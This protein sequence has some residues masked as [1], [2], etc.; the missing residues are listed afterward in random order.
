M[1]SGAH[2]LTRTSLRALSI[3][4]VMFLLQGATCLAQ[5]FDC[6]KATTEIEKTICRNPSLAS[7]DAAMGEVYQALLASLAAGEKGAFKDAQRLWI[8][9]RNRECV[10]SGAASQ[11]NCLKKLIDQRHDELQ[12]QLR[13]KLGLSQM[14]YDWVTSYSSLQDVRAAASDVKDRFGDCHNMPPTLNPKFVSLAPNQYQ[15]LFA[16]AT[17]QCDAVLRVY[18]GCAGKQSCGELL[19]L[20]DPAN[21]QARALGKLEQE[22]RTGNSSGIFVPVAFAKNGRNIILKAW[23]GS[24]G[25]GGGLVNYGYE[26]MPRDGGTSQ[27]SELAP[28]GA[29]FYSDFG[30]AVYTKDSSKLPAF[31]QPGP[32]SNNGL[33][34]AKDLATLKERPVLEEPDTT[35]EILRADERNHT[36]TIRATQHVFSASCP[37]NQ[38]D[39]LLCSKKTAR[40]RQIPLP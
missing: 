13:K 8:E 31:T 40:E 6:A 15:S 24:P 37:R 5:S 20:E 10:G 29:V 39:S 3:F 25:A 34:V 2:L 32:P 22:S 33:L 36:L 9:K 11:Q 28:N 21:K 30:M 35:F 27:R 16:I 12:E 19:I 17:H 26:T 7:S 4:T 23:M 14:A 1:K 38:D 18:L